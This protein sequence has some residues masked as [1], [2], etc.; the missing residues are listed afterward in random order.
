MAKSANRKGNPTADE[1]ISQRD[2]EAKDRSRS[3]AN[4]L[5][6]RG[7]Y[8]D[9]H[10]GKASFVVS[11]SINVILQ[12]FMFRGIMIPLIQ[13]YGIR[14][15]HPYSSDG[16]LTAES[17]DSHRVVLFCYGGPDVPKAYLLGLVYY[18]RRGAC[19]NGY[20]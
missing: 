8:T 2:A 13:G 15:I 9:I 11:Q 20:C 10:L 18:T 6:R 4:D 17:I 7:I 16:S 12:F 5:I 19:L 3:I 14:I 1:L